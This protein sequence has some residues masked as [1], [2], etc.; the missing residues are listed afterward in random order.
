MLLL[1]TGAASLSGQ[2]AISP[3]GT[4]FLLAFPDTTI[5]HIGPFSPYTMTDA[6]LTIIAQDTA[7]VRIS[8]GSF[9][10]SLTILPQSST[11]ISL[12]D[13]MA[14]RPFIDQTDTLL[15]DAIHVTSD[16]PISLLCF[17]FS[18]HG[19]EAF[20]PLPVARW[21]TEYYAMSLRNSLYFHAGNRG[22]LEEN[23]Y[24]DYA[25]A[26]IVIIASEDQTDVTIN[27][28]TPTRRFTDTTIR[29]NRGQAYLI[30]THDPW[31][32]TDTTTRD[33]SGTRIISTR[34]VGVLSGNTRSTGGFG[35]IYLRLPTW[36]SLNNSL[37]EWLPPADSGGNTFVY[38]PCHTRSNERTEEIVRIYAVSPGITSV[39]ASNGFPVRQMRQ[40]EYLQYGFCADAALG[41]P[42]GDFNTPFALRTDQHALAMVVTA[43]LAE[44][45]GLL[46][47]S[48]STYLS[49]SPAMSLLPPREG[50]IT[51]GRFHLPTVPMWME[52]HA[53]IVADSGARVWIDTTEVVFEPDAVV[54]T[55]F[56]HARVALPSGDHAIRSASG[57]VGAIVMGTLRGMEEFRPAGARRKE[58]R[59]L[60]HPSYYIQ[61]MSI[62]YAYPVYGV[63]ASQAPVDSVEI[64]IVEKCDSTV[65]V[66]RRIGPPWLMGPL[67]LEVLPDSTNA[68]MLI[69]SDLQGG[70][71]IGYR[72]RFKAHDSGR[73]ATARLEIT[74]SSG[75]SRLIPLSRPA[76][77]I[78][79]APQPIE[80]LD[81]PIGTERTVDLTLTNRRGFVVTVLTA[82]LRAGRPEFSL[83]GTAS[84]PRPLLPNQTASLT[85]AF[86]G[87]QRNTTYVDTLLVETD[88]GTFE[89]HVRGRVGPDPVPTITGY[90]W[91]ERRV[92]SI[93]DTISF[94][95]NTG[96]R[97]YRIVDVTI[98]N[99][100]DGAFS[101][102]PPTI[103]S[104]DS[105]RPAR[106]EFQGIR[107]V[108]P[109]EGEF[110][111]GIELATDDG[112]TVKA[113]LHGIGVVPRPVVVDLFED[114]LCLGAP[115]SRIIRLRNIGGA[116]ASIDRITLRPSS[117]VTVTLDTAIPFL[118][119][120]ILPGGELRLP[121]TITPARAGA[122][123]I[124]MHVEGDVVVDTTIAT[125]VVRLCVAPE[126]TVTD[127]DFDSVYITLQ[128]EGAVWV[129]NGGGGDVEIT[130]MDLVEDTAASFTI[131]WPTPPFVVPD[132]AE[133]EVRCLFGP[134][135]TGLKSAAIDY[136]TG[137]GSRRSLLRGVGKRLQIPAII[138]RD[139]HA[140]P[141]RESTIH[142]ELQGRLDTLPIGRI[143]VAI[144]YDTGLLDYLAMDVPRAADS[145]WRWFGDRD[146]DTMRAHIAFEG[147]PSRDDTLLSMRYLVRFSTIDSS[148]FP[149]TATVDL[150]YVEIVPNPGLFRRDPIC[151]LEERLFE[152]VTGAFRLEQ[153][154][155][156]PY[157]LTTTI[158]FELPFENPTTLIVYNTYGDEVLRLVDE[159]L[160][161]GQYSL[162]TPSGA[163]PSGVHYY[164]LRSG[165]FV[166]TRRMIVE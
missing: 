138:R 79:V 150:P 134:S 82:R 124:G 73:D 92:G 81:V 112:D 133:V 91:R 102:V 90:D 157:G 52:H 44:P 117:E 36:N 54:G 125:G 145:G 43:S 143:D 19:S 96:S 49:W 135:T 116:P 66:I 17:F 95:G 57:R 27:A 155:P 77:S 46:A 55:P 104:I 101:L 154:R 159:V 139:Y 65:V 108:P 88:C 119:Q 106:V 89:L 30:E 62:A 40:G 166:A 69:E 53:V 23:I 141:G 4:E 87:L 58:A 111:A 21:G 162:T 6:R 51:Y 45:G 126:L 34:P 160:A 161:P 48:S 64:D 129:R 86:T 63:N 60:L 122:F 16:R 137:V 28:T 98:I 110:T 41:V 136:Q 131:L 11:T 80:M 113:T 31:S 71:P 140:P 158:D 85:V 78:L 149:F 93:N 29:L 35:G 142:L 153:N 152:F 67:R 47:D 20:V 151:G 33:L 9:S 84:L 107:F 83:R 59:S 103:S 147:R 56:Q 32:T 74:G 75:V 22:D 114:S 132:G 13:S 7:E 8:S 148:A 68:D 76:T 144:G 72:I 42:R 123:S 24:P 128:R 100:S 2:S 18:P 99:N 163:L 105:I 146:G 97:G 50:W 70:V 165:P 39:A 94:I 127:H 61:A 120:I 14:R 1:T 3:F 15:S 121:L 12:I 164:R 26:Q 156:N 118:P 10:R 38:R 37:V 130:A 115:R 25:P 5:A 109:R